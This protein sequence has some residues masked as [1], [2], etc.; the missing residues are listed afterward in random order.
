MAGVAGLFSVDGV[1][2]SGLGP[3]GTLGTLAA[4]S[5][6]PSWIQSRITAISASGSF[7]WPRGICGA[8]DSC[9][10]ALN[11]RLDVGRPAITISPDPPPFTTPL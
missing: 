10:T 2:S 11:K 3:S 1:K 9:E 6:R 8:P 5:S 7:A 4:V